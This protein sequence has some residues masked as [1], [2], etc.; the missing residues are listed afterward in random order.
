MTIGLRFNTFVAQV[1]QNACPN[2]SDLNAMDMRQQCSPHPDGQIH[3]HHLL[4]CHLTR[5]KIKHLGL[6][7]A[8]LFAQVGP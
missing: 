3:A 2:G 7:L 4:A 1:A 6:Q 5:T 8:E